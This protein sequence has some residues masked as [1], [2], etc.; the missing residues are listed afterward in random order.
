MEWEA[1]VLRFNEL[2]RTIKTASVW[3]VRQPIYKTSKAKWMRYEKYLQPLIKGT[4]AK[5]EWDPIE[6]ITLPEPGF[7]QKVV[8]LYREGKLDDAEMN[9]KKMLH[10]NPGHA[11]CNY[12]LGLVYLS[13]NHMEEGVGLIEQALKRAPWNKEWRATLIHAYEVTGQED[14][15]AELEQLSRKRSETALD[16]L[17]EEEVDHRMPMSASMT[18]F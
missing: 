12:M 9:F 4:N 3:Q 1:D 18:D 2:D 5:I 15:I 10:H 14:K 17:A 16:D 7:L 8:A 11:G 6:M 13:K